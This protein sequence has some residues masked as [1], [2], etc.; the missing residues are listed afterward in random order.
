MSFLTGF[1]VTLDEI[2]LLGAGALAAFAGA[3]TPA[4]WTVITSAA[5][6]LGAQYQDG[7]YYTDGGSGATAIV[8]QQGSEY[9][10]AFRG[11]DGSNDVSHYPELDRK[12]VV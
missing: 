8:L 12:S 10:V 5:L 11:T 6:G 7:N 2:E 4:G 1:N 9:I 3:P